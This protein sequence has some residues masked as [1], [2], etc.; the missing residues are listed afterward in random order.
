MLAAAEMAARPTPKEK[1]Y[2]DLGARYVFEPIALETLGVYNVS[3]RHLLDDLGR[4]ISLNSGE[5]RE[6]IYMYQKI[7]VAYWCSASILSYCTTVCQPLT[8]WIDDRTDIFIFCS[9][10]KLPRDY[11]SEDKTNNNNNN[12]NNNPRDLYYRG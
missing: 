8:A 11:I 12:N 5:A 4:R 9:I 7:S 10:F 2:V 3:A 1:K 6:T